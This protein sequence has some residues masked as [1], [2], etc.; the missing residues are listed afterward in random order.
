MF[1]RHPSGPAAGLTFINVATGNQRANT[2]S[3][4][5]TCTGTVGSASFACSLGNPVPPGQGRYLT[6]D[7][8]LIDQF[9]NVVTN[10][11]GSDLT[12]SLSQTVSTTA[13]AA[14]SND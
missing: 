4:S 12:V 8:S 7:V 9:Q 2:R 11:S 5:V 3:P 14:C 1:V 10:T 13:S 6:A